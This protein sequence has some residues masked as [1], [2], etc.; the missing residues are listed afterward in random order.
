MQDFFGIDIG[1]HKIKIAQIIWEDNQPKVI[2]CAD[3]PVPPNSIEVDEQKKQ[4]LLIEALRS[5]MQLAKVTTKNVVGALSELSVTS[6]LEVG[7]PKLAEVEL[8]E[9]IIYEAK[10]YITYPIDQMQLDKVIVGERK[11]NGVDVIDVFWVA[12][13]KTNVSKYLSLFEKAG[14]FVM[15]LETESIASA[16]LVNTF[17]RK[18]EQDYNPEQAVLVVDIGS[19]T[20]IVSV[21]KNE[22]VLF[23]QCLG[24]GSDAMTK[25]IAM[26]YDLD[27]H[28]AET[29]KV[30]YGLN[31]NFAE[32]KFADVLKPLAEMLLENVSKT[33]SFFMTKVPNTIPSVVYL[34]GDGSQLPNFADYASKKLKMPVVIVDG[35]SCLNLSNELKELSKESPKIGHNVAL[36]LALKRPN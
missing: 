9:A 2:G 29:Y 14:L 10:K 35:L 4:Q 34:T 36:G 24:S 11:V 21:V 23:S 7:F 16:R 18:F 25:V 26:T 28:T 6:R 15:A 30:T 12:T 33:I 22:L 32:G 5:C 27:E 13:S 8:N 20:T 17:R 1:Q 3:F 19:S 31:P